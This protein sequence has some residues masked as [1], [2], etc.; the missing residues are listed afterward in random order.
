MLHKLEIIVSDEDFA[1][2]E[3]LVAQHAVYGWEEESLPT[4]ETL[5]KVHCEDAEVLTFL[6]TEV[7]ALLPSAVFNRSE[8]EEQNWLDAWK[9]FFT[10]VETGKFLILP[11]WLEHSPEAEQ[12][13][14]KGLLPIII[15]PKSAFGTGHHPTTTLCLEAISRLHDAGKI[16]A[17]QRFLDLGTG[18]GVLGIGCIGLGLNGLGVDIDPLAVSNAAENRELN[19]VDSAFEVMSGSVD[20][21]EGQT[22]DLVIANILAAPLKEMAQAIMALVKPGGGLILSGF[23]SVQVEGLEAAYSAMPCTPGRLS[24]P[25]PV[26]DPTRGQSDAASGSTS[27]PSSGDEWVCLYWPAV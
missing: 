20:V 14:A 21:V 17:G 7:E 15:E 18:T 1:L 9:E 24:A 22:F 12:G 8:V 19:R 26:S 11:P 25:S 6:R 2:G 16:Q 23:L 10:P 4:G 5:F 27:S 3:A 13:K